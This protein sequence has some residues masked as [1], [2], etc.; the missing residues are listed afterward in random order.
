MAL[1]K[2]ATSGAPDHDLHDG[3]K[4]IADDPEGSSWLDRMLGRTEREPH[5]PEHDPLISFA[6]ERADAGITASL[7]DPRR[8]PQPEQPSTPLPA[9]LL[10]VIGATAAAVAFGAVE[11]ARTRAARLQADAPQ[12]GRL[13]VT[14]S[15][16]GAEILIDGRPS[17][18]SPLTVSLDPGGHLLTVRVEGRERSLPVTIKPGA[19]VSQYYEGP[20]AASRTAGG[21]VSVITDPPGAR[22][23]ID[24]VPRG[25]SPA[26]I[27]NV[28]P[29]EHRVTVTSDAGSGERLVLVEP[30]GSASMVFSLSKPGGTGAGWLTVAAPFDVQ[31]FEKD[32]VIGASGATK[33]MLPAGR[34]DLLLV[35]RTLEYQ[36]ARRVDVAAGKVAAL[37]VTP[38]KSSLSVNARPWAD[39]VID[40]IAAGQTPIANVPMAIGSHQVVFRHPQF[41][42]R[43]QT[44]TVTLKGPNRV[45]VDLTK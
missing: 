17:G 11:I 6:P 21:R 9:W 18:T 29:G 14:T 10:I 20:P 27:A 1:S 41:G 38:P 35:N 13:V 44:V 23:A 24:G 40:G 36:E 39:V 19:E 4:P 12:P 43:R 8:T 34:H 5:E 45:A 30:N 22:V 15:P 42:E 2:R 37:R 26:L 16:S 31:V 25:T 33:I 32:E 7:P 28:T 3:D